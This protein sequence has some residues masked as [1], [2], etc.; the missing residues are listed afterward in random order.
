VEVAGKG[1]GQIKAKE[2]GT[3]SPSSRGAGVVG[4]VW[5]HT[6]NMSSYEDLSSYKD[7]SRIDT[8][9]DSASLISL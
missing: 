5:P 2:L 8:R 9:V 4:G 7:S 1:A 3:G 6:V